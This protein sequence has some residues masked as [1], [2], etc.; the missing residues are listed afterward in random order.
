M[1]SLSVS[2]IYIWAQTDNPYKREN[3]RNMSLLSY[4]PLMQTERGGNPLMK[5]L[6]WGTFQIDLDVLLC[7]LYESSKDLS[8]EI[9]IHVNAD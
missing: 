8:E 5:L 2:L 6:R 4:H 9:N 3:R 7:T 1:R